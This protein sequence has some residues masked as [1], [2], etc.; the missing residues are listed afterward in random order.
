MQKK[1]KNI[2]SV[3]ESSFFRYFALII[4]FA[5][6]SLFF[7]GCGG[8]DETSSTTQFSN[9]T[10]KINNKEKTGEKIL[11]ESYKVSVN[12]DNL[13]MSFSPA[14]EK[15]DDFSYKS[16][17]TSQLRFRS[18]PSW[19]SI[20]KI[21]SGSVAITNKNSYDTLY[22]SELRVESV[23][24][25]SVS[26]SN[27][28]GISGANPYLYYGTIQGNSDTGVRVLKFHDPSSV[29]FSFVV[30]LYANLL[31]GGDGIFTEDTSFPGGASNTRAVAG[32]EL[33]GNGQ[34]DVLFGN[35]GELNRLLVN[36]GG[37]SFL[38]ESAQR[39]PS[40]S[41]F[42]SSLKSADI[43]GD[44]DRDIIE[45]NSTNIPGDTVHIMVNDGNGNFTDESAQRINIA[46]SRYTQD[47]AVQDIDDDGDLDIFT[48]NSL[49]TDNR[50][51]IN[52][53]NGF[54]TDETS[55][56]LP[57]GINKCNK[58]EIADFSGD[59]KYDIFLAQDGSA[60]FKLLIN[61]GSGNFTDESSSRLPADTANNFDI[62]AGD[63]DG[64][65]DT[66][67]FVA[68]ENNNG[69][70]DKLLI[71]NGT[72]VFTDESAT[73]LPQISDF[74]LGCVTADF[75]NDND[76]DIFVVN[77]GTQNR[78]YLNNGAG[79]FTDV[80]S[81]SL[82]ADTSL[83]LDVFLYDV[84]KNGTPDIIIGNNN[85]NTLLLD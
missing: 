79:V 56:R 54:Y 48:C 16:K 57:A 59:D 51:L 31:P 14:S 60:K 72:G 70:Q 8:I 19:D 1:G 71:N 39:I 42:T 22:D 13:T 78:M 4:I 76:L 32:G 26:V 75:D 66:D 46:S 50:I 69:N 21:L 41:Y 40:T 80:S 29:S 38:D 35:F 2:T 53:G 45:T 55:S 11:I 27:E 47:S 82:P 18:V 34:S 37:T 9:S 10:D 24:P 73:R 52:N 61:D 74:S 33:S 44:G 6:S 81:S 12:L 63:Y 25:S 5:S 49:E 83:S 3:T 58:V 67:I 85:Q 30:N 84:D 77:Y 28:D 36:Q 64:D 20:Q 7:S 15:K 23:T 65:G 68:N 43:D 17:I 62:C